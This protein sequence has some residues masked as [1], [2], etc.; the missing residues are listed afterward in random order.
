VFL[1]ESGSNLTISN[2]DTSAEA[3]SVFLGAGA[4]LEDESWV[5]LLGH[6]GFVI[7]SDVAEA[8]AVMA[9]IDEVGTKFTYRDMTE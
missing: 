9:K 5:K 6:N 7:A 1:F 4:R 3:M 8:E 2:P